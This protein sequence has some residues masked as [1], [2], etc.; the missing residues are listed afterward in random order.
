[1]TDQNDHAGQ[2]TSW[3]R[4]IL[5]MIV[6]CLPGLPLLYAIRTFAFQPFSIPSVSSFPNAVAGDYVFVSKTAYGYSKYSFPNWFPG[7][8]GRIWSEKPQRGDM[9]VFRLPTDTN[10]D[11]IKRVVGLPGDHIQM[12]QSQLFIN[13]VA[14]KQE[15]IILESAF[16][17]QDSAVQ[18]FRETLPNGR[19]YV[20]ANL[21]N[22]GSADNTAEYIVPAG[23]YFVLGDNRDNS[24]DSRFL[25]KV[26]SIP[27]DNFIGPV[28]FRFF[29]SKGFP[30]SNRPTETYPQ[31]QQ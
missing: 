4:I 19:S 18:F 31:Q 27:E 23:H 22:D 20:I 15:P 16:Y 11:Y 21:F 9:A 28:V 5:L 17:E 25:G 3:R 29:N 26:G 14:A 7:F 13:G 12:R 2:K 30:I 6:A 8:A 24:L 10:I 1:M